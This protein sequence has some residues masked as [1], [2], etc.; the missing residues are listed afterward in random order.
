M[1]TSHLIAAAALA[2][3]P[4]A[5][6]A[7]GAGPSPA[8]GSYGAPQQQEEKKG[9]PWGLL[10]LLGLIGLLPMRKKSGS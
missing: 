1:R 10:G 3:T 7:Q 2:L 4:A 9:F 6:A 5:A 8:E